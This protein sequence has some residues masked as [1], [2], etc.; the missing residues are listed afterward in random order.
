MEDA[1]KKDVSHDVT[2]SMYHKSCRPVADDIFTR[3]EFIMNLTRYVRLVTAGVTA[4]AVVSTG[5]YASQPDSELASDLAAVERTVTA[6]EARVGD[7]TG[8]LRGEGARIV[9]TQDA[10]SGVKVEFASGRPLQVGLP[11][12]G[13][14]SSERVS[15]SGRRIV[16]G[17]NAFD[18]VTQ[19]D[20][21][22]APQFL[23]VL[24]SKSAPRDYTFRPTFGENTR[25]E[26]RGN[27]GAAIFSADKKDAV[28]VAPPWAVDAN[29]RSV[30]TH[31]EVRGAALVQV[32]DHRAGNFAYPIV[33]DPKYKKRWF[34]AGGELVF[35]IGETRA[36]A[37]NVQAV[38]ATL[39]GCSFLPGGRLVCEGVGVAIRAAAGY[40]KLMADQNKC[41]KFY[42]SHVPGVPTPSIINTVPAPGGQKR[43]DFGCH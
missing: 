27:G 35:N 33:A 10:G 31:F 23:A 40:F 24:R 12:T 26:L 9:A 8:L 16:T 6:A 32:V 36:I 21:T 1:L 43:G 3:E 41:A 13:G 37:Q 38:A 4:I 20:D 7:S 2:R 18:L 14:V 11:E 39:G 42:V 28:E 15:P 5:A 29:G 19:V 25:V 22:G 34:G 17:R 30:P